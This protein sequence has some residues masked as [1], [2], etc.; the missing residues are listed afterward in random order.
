MRITQGS[1]VRRKKKPS[2]KKKKFSRL[3]LALALNKNILEMS[4][5]QLLSAAVASSPLK[6]HRD[7]K[8]IFFCVCTSRGRENNRDTHTD[9]KHRKKK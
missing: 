7:E 2:K 6:N 3:P 9:R 8:G 5:L 1:L 4:H